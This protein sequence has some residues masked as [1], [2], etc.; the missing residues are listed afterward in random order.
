[1]VIDEKAFNETY[2]A[3]LEAG[4]PLTPPELR[5]MFV[6][7]ESSRHQAQSPVVGDLPARIKYTVAD[8]IVIEGRTKSDVVQDVWDELK[9]YLHPTATTQQSDAELSFQYRVKPW[10][11]ACFGDEIANDKV[12]RNHRFIEEALELV[13]SCGGTKEE[14]H[15]LV[16]Y[17]FSRPTGDPVQES[18]GVMVTH[19]A[20]CLANNLDMH[21]SGELELKRIWGKVEQIREKQ[22]NKPRNSPLPQHTATDRDDWE[23]IKGTL[24]PIKDC[25]WHGKWR[26]RKVI[27]LIDAKLAG[28]V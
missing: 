5:K 28:G 22:K 7:Y 13:Q 14:C 25:G 23:T 2:A 1:M 26:I 20:L 11:A 27:A 3:F 15:M 24:E 6:S 12:E 8:N 21:Q 17:V 18:G 19:A 4:K 16:D 10:M 9:P